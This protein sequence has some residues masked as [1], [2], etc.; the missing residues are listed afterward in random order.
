MEPENFNLFT[1]TLNKIN[2]PGKNS[3]YRD[4]ISR[5]KTLKGLLTFRVIQ[6]RVF[7]FKNEILRFQEAGKEINYIRN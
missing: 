3:D 4:Q 7:W 1:R 5:W 6:T 2:K